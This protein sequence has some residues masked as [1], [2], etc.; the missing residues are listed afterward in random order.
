[1]VESRHRGTYAVI[2]RGGRVLDA[3]GDID[4]RVYPRSAIKP[5]QALALVASGAADAFAVTDEEIALACASHSGEP[6]HV[7]AVRAW[8]DRLG[9]R[10]D[11]LECGAHAPGHAPSLMALHRDGRAP[12]Q[13]HN[14]CSGKHTGMLT[15]CR[16]LGLTTRGYIAWDHPL[17]RRIAGILGEL[18]DVDADAAP[19]GIDGCGLPQIGLPLRALALGYARFGAPDGLPHARAC[20]RIAA[21]MIAH[22][23]MVAGTDRF[24]TRALIAARGKVV[25]KTG[26]EGVYLAAVPARGMA[27]A[28]K[29]D[30]GA[31]RAAEVV[32]ARLMLEWGALDPQ[33]RDDVEALTRPPVVNVAGLS[34][35]AIAPAPTWR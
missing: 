25:L 15:A 10:E 24:C 33:A 4:R 28:I 34:V 14:N 13:A 1:M 12:S 8:L 3:R 11:D 2:D 21:S 29:I 16:H 26:A 6:R 22:P 31:G 23:F 32:M 17:Q 35:G 19:R 30:D 18:C 5:L 27:I 7:E 20:Q 9:L